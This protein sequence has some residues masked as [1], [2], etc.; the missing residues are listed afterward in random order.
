[1]EKLLLHVCCAPCSIAIL[2]E[3][4]EQFILQV[5][6]YNPNI[7]PDTEYEKRKK[8]VIRVCQ[9]MNI[10]YT[11]G[12]YRPQDWE[13]V[14]GGG[15]EEPEGGDRCLA[16]FRLRLQAAA[17]QAQD[18]GCHI[19]TTSLTM[20]RNKD[21]R[22]INPLGQTIAQENGL[23][24]LSEDWKKNGR[25]EKAVRLVREKNIYR[26]DYCGCRFSLEE[27]RRIKRSKT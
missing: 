21:A 10:P 17:R 16:C 7:Y 19:F 23:E 4:A 8:E 22:K 24:Y 14:A 26:Q 9:E 12:V 6:F 1:M 20:G 11:D 25:Q 27:S 2:S 18:M 3:L 15:G 13:T 5:F